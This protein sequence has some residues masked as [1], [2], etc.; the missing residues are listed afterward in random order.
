MRGEG[1]AAGGRVDA[2]D[3]EVGGVLVGADEPA[4]VGRE[5]EVAR[6]LAAAGDALDGG[7][8]TGVGGER[9]NGKGEGRRS[10]GAG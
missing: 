8:A 3:G 1:E 6:V 2:E 4:A 9:E 5:G 10:F 7:E